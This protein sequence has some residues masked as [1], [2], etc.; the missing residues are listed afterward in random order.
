M[1]K[2]LNF[3]NEEIV[4]LENILMYKKHINELR[5]SNERLPKKQW[6]LT[7]K[8]NRA[9]SNLERKLLKLKDEVQA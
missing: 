3:T 8:E 5:M 1:N 6:L 9:I 2:E 4:L 7:Q